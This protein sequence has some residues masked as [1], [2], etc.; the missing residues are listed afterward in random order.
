MARKTGQI[1]RR[2]PEMW[3]VRIYLGCDPEN[4]RRPVPTALLNRRANELRTDVALAEVSF[5]HK[6]LLPRI[7]LLCLDHV[8]CTPGSFYDA[9]LSLSSSHLIMAIRT[10]WTARRPDVAT[11]L[12]LR[13]M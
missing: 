5:V 11:D 12:Y 3:M 7:S 4:L 1:I 13:V 10:M 6:F 8:V 9:P 2:G